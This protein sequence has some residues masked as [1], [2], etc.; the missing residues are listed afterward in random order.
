MKAVIKN[1]VLFS[2]LVGLH[3][4]GKN[5]SFSSSV[6]LA[7]I[8]V[9]S[10]L[11]NGTSRSVSPSSNGRY[12]AF[13]SN[14]SNLV[15]GDTNSATDV[16]VFDKQT[17][18]TIR[19]SVDS[20]GAQGNGRSYNPVI[21]GNGQFV[22]F[23]STA[24]NL[25]S[26]DTNFCSDI[27]VRDLVNNVTTRVSVGASGVQAD[28]GSDTP[29]ISND[30]RYVGFRSE[31]TNLIGSSDTNDKT[32]FFIRD[33][34]GGTTSIV[35][36]DTSGAL[37]ND[38]S[39]EGKISGD[40]NF[41]VFTSKASNLVSGDTNQCVDIFLRDIVNSTTSLISK[42]ASSELG[43]R[44]STN[45]DISSDGRY[46]VFQSHAGNLVANDTNGYSDIFLV[47]ITNSTIER[48]SLKSGLDQ[49]SSENVNPKVSDDGRFV[50]FETY[51]NDL[52]PLDANNQ[53]DIYLRDRTSKLTTLVSSASSVAGNSWSTSGDISND[54]KFLVFT[55]FAS[56]LVSG[57]MNGRSDVFY[58]Q[59]LVQDNVV[60]VFLKDPLVEESGTQDGFEFKRYGDTS[61]S[62]TVN[63]SVS[64]TA[65][66]GVDYT[67]LSGSIV[68]G[69]GESSKILQVSVI[70]DSTV[71]APESIKIDITASSTV[72]PGGAP[73]ATN[74]ISSSEKFTVSVT[75]DSNIVTED[76]GVK[77]KFTLSRSGGTL[78]EL[79]IPITIG[80][81]ATLGGD[82]FGIS[83]VLTIPDGQS[84]LQFQITGI[85][86]DL[87]EG[88]ES[89]SITLNS[90]TGYTVGS[91]SVVNMTLKD[92]D[93]IE[94]SVNAIDPIAVEGDS[95]NPG[96][97][98][99]KLS[100]STPVSLPIFYV[101]KG[102][103]TNGVDYPFLS[104]VATVP[105]NSSYVDVTLSA[106]SDVLTEGI[107]S[108]EME[109]VEGPLYRVGIAKFATVL[110]QENFSLPIVS[111]EATDAMAS[112]DGTNTG[113][114]RIS[115][116]GSTSG[117][118]T[119]NF[120][121]GGTAASGADYS[122]IGTSAVIPIGYSYV[123]VTVQGIDDLLA[124]EDETVILALSATSNYDIDVDKY[125]AKITIADDDAPVVSVFARSS[126]ASDTLK[127]TGE[128]VLVRS[129]DL[130]G[131][132]TVNYTVSGSASTANDYN[133]IGT[134]ATFLPFEKEHSIFV[135]AKTDNAVEGTKSVVL[136]LASGSGYSNS[137]PLIARVAILDNTL[138]FTNRLMINPNGE[139]RD[140][141]ISDD[142]RYIV[143]SSTA[144]NISPTVD[145]NGVS[146]IFLI[147]TQLIPGAGGV[148]RLL[149][150]SGLEANG[151]SYQPRM[152]ADGRYIVFTTRATNFFLYDQVRNSDVVLFDR[153]TGVYKLVSGG[154]RPRS[155]NDDS[156]Y[157]FISK[158]G[159]YVVFQSSSSDLVDG[160]TN[161]VSDI[162]RFNI[163]SGELTRANSTTSLPQ[164][165]NGSFRPSVDESGAL[166]TFN[167]KEQIDG[168]LDSYQDAIL[169]NINS[170][171]LKR[172]SKP[173]DGFKNDD[174]SFNS[175][176]TPNGKQVFFQ[177][178]A[179]TIIDGD[180]NGSVDLFQNLVSDELVSAVDI[181]P[182]GLASSGV[183]NF[184][185][186]DRYATFVS[187]SQNLGPRLNCRN[188]VF[189]K[190]TYS[191]YLNEIDYSD[192]ATCKGAVTQSNLS[193]DGKMISS[194][195]LVKGQ[196]A[197]GAYYD[198][199]VSSNPLY[200][201]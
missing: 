146:D 174:D 193:P 158:N 189:V 149:T 16:F 96:V 15:S 39:S 163:D 27:F 131:S 103:A 17:G 12:I 56:N 130:S 23:V 170:N 173:K 121:V 133:S 153:V 35:S 33:T 67:A 138:I 155:P 84:S 36:V 65:T 190:G 2:L 28:S 191:G 5:K 151:P 127:K 186:N 42:D 128:F 175:I 4:Y 134:S 135:T 21:S 182:E 112:E 88:D 119:V 71:E 105:A 104:G 168:D 1:L 20:S 107:E 162:F 44:A 142:G 90:G 18:T 192:P 6:S 150:P 169:V 144:S 108:A 76:G 194:T 197:T 58:R 201:E 136:T 157:P 50:V 196:L 73:S 179:S 8:G 148:T 94:A 63:Y 100:A 188:T 13:E 159:K 126:I 177:S 125:R 47:D 113:K 77:G 26:G 30:G 83:N 141:S 154:T 140:A 62:L 147:D 34:V 85:R 64:G 118:L 40:G 181:G 99:I 37:A 31:A 81:S 178:N 143:F 95:G 51:A 32:D 38:H 171:S 75:T 10:S 80:G 43:N 98:R 9:S 19:A 49:V 72:V 152:S 185:I 53:W 82:Y 57:D 29:S 166:I 25:V 167:S 117:A 176:I 70:D 48:V 97:F 7:S 66:S 164:F 55:S 93:S 101:M 78:G 89:I 116:T 156:E 86:D 114:F 92:S 69:V 172:I 59:N 132:L 60:N 87:A 137:S 139:I 74:F 180:S 106:D 129:G 14:A 3:A 198:I 124:E 61:S 165:A 110:I 54:G 45:P 161:G 183:V 11:A 120:N 52:D 109:L 145:N 79:K 111:V 122:S 115:R 184:S 200:F 187:S 123:D 24:T 68:F 22:A 41:F 195:V 160:D 199:L 102:T 46:V 91:P